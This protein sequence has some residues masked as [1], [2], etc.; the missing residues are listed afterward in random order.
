MQ[1]VKEKAGVVVWQQGS[2]K[3]PLVLLVS[4]RKNKGA[5]VFP[6]GSVEPGE[7]LPEAAARECLEESGSCV[8]IGPHLAA[9]EAPNAGGIHSRF[10]FYL[11]EVSSETETWEQDRS[12]IWVP[13]SEAISL[14]PD[15]FKDVA[16]EAQQRIK[17]M[18]N[19]DE[20]QRLKELLLAKSYRKGTFTLTSGKTSDFYIDGKQTTLDA[21]GGWL[22][23][24]L[25][26]ELIRQA[27]QPIS[28]VGGMTLGAD[29]LVTAV[30]IASYLAGNPIPAFIV[31]K[32]AK[33]HGTGNY[34]EGKNNLHP[35]CSVAL[36]E[37]VVTTGGTLL[38]V[39]E[40]VEKEGF[41]VG[42]VLTVIDRDEGGAEV[43]AQAGY[44]LHSVFTRTQLIG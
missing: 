31:R 32:E 33:G 2:G 43:L 41:R 12:R 7:S 16:R 38:K 39:I 13:L 24:R 28:G 15:I 18:N 4:S 5:W 26:F 23:G 20:R 27:P 14:L 25:L 40:R 9:V 36:L 11:A 37:D 19:A 34:L 30:S 10:T 22:C 44:P 17:S 3:E 8:R 1:F 35:G 21:E 6:V 29:P 42:M